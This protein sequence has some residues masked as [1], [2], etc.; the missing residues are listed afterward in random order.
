[1]SRIV[2]DAALVHATAVAGRTAI[3]G[4]EQTV[5]R[6]Q[7]ASDEAM[8]VARK[9]PLDLFAGVGVSALGPG[10]VSQ[11]KLVGEVVSRNCDQLERVA[12]AVEAAEADAHYD[13]ESGDSAA[14]VDAWMSGSVALDQMVEQLLTDSGLAGIGALIASVDGSQPAAE[15]LGSAISAMLKVTG[16]GEIERSFRD[17]AMSRQVL[18]VQVYAARN[19]PAAATALLSDFERRRT[20]I[21]G[22]LNPGLAD[23]VGDVIRSSLVS[24]RSHSFKILDDILYEIGNELDGDAHYDPVDVV[25]T[26]GQVVREAL[27]Q[28]FAAHIDQLLSDKRAEPYFRSPDRQDPTSREDYLTSAMASL[29]AGDLARVEINRAIAAW[30]VNAVRT[31]DAYGAGYNYAL[32]AGAIKKAELAAGT[33]ANATQ[34]L[35]NKAA[36]ELFDA[37]LGLSLSLVGKTIPFADLPLSVALSLA[38]SSGSNVDW[39]TLKAGDETQNLAKNQAYKML[40][41]ILVAAYGVD[42]IPLP[43]EGSSAQAVQDAL[44]SGA[45]EEDWP[46]VYLE[47]LH[48]RK[49]NEE[50]AVTKGAVM[51]GFDQGFSRFW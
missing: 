6:V 50:A 24:D 7:E 35:G 44:Q 47:T 45:P 42:N 3:R 39:E 21:G 4:L 28:G 40:Q 30:S 31:G 27:A 32:L 49:P 22:S 10:R 2:V 41:P 1:M 51:D 19:V 14:D 33:A 36:G 15:H 9:L 5:R 25:T 34:D 43:V 46:S 13:T 17:G 18:A 26:Y 37:G 8:A 16:R 48:D 23:C 11:S 38:R 12:A 29:Y 20:V